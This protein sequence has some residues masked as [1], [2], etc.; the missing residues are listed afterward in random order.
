MKYY[1]DYNLF[2]LPLPKKFLL[3]ESIKLLNHEDIF[4]NHLSNGGSISRIYK[5][6][7][8]GYDGRGEGHVLISACRSTGTG[9]VPFSPPT[10]REDAGPTEKTYIQRQRHSEVAA[11]HNH[12]KL[13][14]PYLLVDDPQTGEQY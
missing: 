2:V 3:P 11:G 7:L 4:A 5:E 9:F 12:D 6:L 8:I 10:T 1:R 13:G 14:A